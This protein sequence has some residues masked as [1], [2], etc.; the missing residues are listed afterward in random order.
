M[1]QDHSVSKPS[2]I[3]EKIKIR[4]KTA[5][6]SYTVIVT[7]ILFVHQNIPTPFNAFVCN[8]NSTLQKK[9]GQGIFYFV[10]DITFTVFPTKTT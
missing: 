7:T 2:I 8:T 5:Y 9:E 1:H 10:I 6:F 4:L 3:S